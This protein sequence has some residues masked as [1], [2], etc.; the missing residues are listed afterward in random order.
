MVVFCNTHTFG[1]SC[2]L[3]LS[4]ICTTS[5]QEEFNSV[6]RQL[7]SVWANLRTLARN[8][9][10]VACRGVMLEKLII[11]QIKKL[12]HLLFVIQTPSLLFLFCLVLGQTNMFPLN[13]PR[14]ANS[15]FLIKVTIIKVINH[16]RDLQLK[17]GKKGIIYL[18]LTLVWI[19]KAAS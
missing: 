5:L 10:Q 18:H 6:L 17:Q 13:S 16:C 2:C 7:P 14:F 11:G 4:Y 3:S 15:I 1:S 19:L 8:V 12:Y 9:P